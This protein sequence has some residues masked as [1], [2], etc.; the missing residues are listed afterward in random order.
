VTELPGRSRV[1]VWAHADDETYCA[2]G[3]LAAAVAAG[4][5]VVCV[6]ATHATGPRARELEAALAVLGVTEHRHL[7]HEDGGC[8]RVDPAGPAAVLAGLLA[9]VRPDTVVTFGPDGHTGHPDHRAVSRWVDR[10]LATAALPGVRLLHPAV[11]DRRAAR[12][13]D[14]HA[15]FPVFDPGLPVTVPESDLALTLPLGG[16]L[17]D[18]KLRAL[19]AHDSQTRDLREAMGADRYAAWVD[20]E[21]FTA[22]P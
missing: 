2:G 16:E 5:R 12:F 18:R 19:A 15:R 8:A 22:A 9:D 7:G 1:T 17:L 13:A 21:E 14:L 20:R 11:S 4:C 10:A 6:T 3:L